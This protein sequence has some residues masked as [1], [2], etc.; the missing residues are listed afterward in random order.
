[1]RGIPACI[2]VPDTAKQVKQTRIESY[3]VK[4]IECAPY[5]WR[6]RAEANE[7][8][9]QTGATF[10]ATLRIKPSSVDRDGSLELFIVS[11]PDR[12]HS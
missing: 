6:Q 4:I 3:V 2:V 10:I 11:V 9:A 1:L 5:S 12:I 8:V 7:F